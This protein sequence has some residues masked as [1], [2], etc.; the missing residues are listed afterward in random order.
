MR[1]FATLDHDLVPLGPADLG[2]HL[3]DQACYGYVQR[4]ARSRAWYLW[5]G[6]AMFDLDRIPLSR[7]NFG[8]D[9]LLGLDTGGRMWTTLYKHM[10]ADSFREAPIRSGVVPGY[11]AVKLHHVFDDWFHIG[12]VSY[13]DGNQN[14]VGAMR[15]SFDADPDRLIEATR[16]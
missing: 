1:R 4:H 11:E 13:R 16:P 9:R 10:D 15:A 6:Y 14:A 5:P 2:A 8:T 3:K 12:Q 7:I